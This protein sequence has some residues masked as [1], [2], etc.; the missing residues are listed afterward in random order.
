M[1][2]KLFLVPALAS[3]LMLTG[4]AH[5]L[6]RGSV[7]MKVSEDEAHVC[8]DKSEAKVGDRVTLF[9]NAC[10]GTGGGGRSGLGSSRSCS[11][12]EVGKGTV[13]EILNQHYSVVKFD[14]G[15]AFEEG[16]FV[17]KRQE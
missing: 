5:N 1:F 2:Q 9:K 11:K 4:C 13:K 3:G 7:A 15:V 16:T 10:T 17:E 6:M 12:V 8:M 14:P